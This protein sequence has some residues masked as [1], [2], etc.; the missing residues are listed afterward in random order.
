[1]LREFTDIIR[2]IRASDLSVADHVSLHS[3][4][5]QLNQLTRLHRTNSSPDTFC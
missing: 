2:G 4:L 5:D 1:M 3:F